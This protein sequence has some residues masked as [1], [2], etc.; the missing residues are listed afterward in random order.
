MTDEEFPCRTKTISGTN[1]HVTIWRGKKK[2]GK[3][4]GLTSFSTEEKAKNFC[5]G[6]SGHPYYEITPNHWTEEV[7]IECGKKEY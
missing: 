7:C 6:L 2:T 5:E 1:Y 3:P 4:S